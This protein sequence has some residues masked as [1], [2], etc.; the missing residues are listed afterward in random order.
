MR[1]QHGFKVRW[2]LHG[3]DHGVAF[4]AMETPCKSLSIARALASSFSLPPSL[5]T[6]SL[7]PQI[8]GI[9]E[10][11]PY[12]MGSCNVSVWVGDAIY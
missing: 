9:C 6:S 2:D 11:H 5:P 12:I 3:R 4:S 1:T 7:L 8:I 10:Y